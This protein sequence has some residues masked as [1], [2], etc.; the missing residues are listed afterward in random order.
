VGGSREDET[1]ISIVV[2]FTRIDAP[3][4]DSN[5]TRKVDAFTTTPDGYFPLERL[6]LKM[7]S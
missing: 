6:S 5:G 3:D 1:W 2:Q 7:G 4:A